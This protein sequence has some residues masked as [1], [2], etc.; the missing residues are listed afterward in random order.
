MRRLNLSNRGA[1][2][3]VTEYTSGRVA[4]KMM[5]Q[6]VF[7]LMVDTLSSTAFHEVHAVSWSM[8]QST[9]PSQPWYET[10]QQ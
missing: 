7:R 1:I 5:G 3:W 10:D 6:S 4:E 9:I 8:S 2:S